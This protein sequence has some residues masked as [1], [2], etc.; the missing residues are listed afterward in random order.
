LAYQF[1]AIAPTESVV[2]GVETLQW[3]TDN[4]GSTTVTIAG[5]QTATIATG[6]AP[7]SSATWD[8]TQIPGGSY[9]LVLVVLN[10][11]GQVVQQVDKNVVV[12]NSV[13]WHSGTL[14]SS[15]TWSASQVQA[16]DGDVIVP[17]GVTLTIDPGTIV[18]VLQGAQIIVQSGGTLIATG[19]TN[20]PVTFTTFDDFTIGGDTD[21]NQGTSLPTPGEWNGIGV[22]AGGTFTS[23]RPLGQQHLRTY[24]RLQRALR[25]GIDQR[26]HPYHHRRRNG[27]G[28]GRS[29][30]QHELFCRH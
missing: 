26:Q 7:F 28:R 17:A 6:T 2:H 30:R 25:T 20:T 21:F 27:G 14:T 12:N 13:V 3:F 24:C 29:I 1:R 10:N 23:D 15:Q 19:T 16:L 11:S 18:K 5:P 22:L 9:Q 4:G 8:T